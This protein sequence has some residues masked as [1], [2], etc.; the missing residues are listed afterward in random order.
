MGAIRKKDGAQGDYWT[1]GWASALR[2]ADR[3]TFSSGEQAR[4]AP[5]RAPIFATSETR[6]IRAKP[7]P[8]AHPQGLSLRG[9]RAPRRRREALSSIAKEAAHSTSVRLQH[10]PWPSALIGSY[11]LSIVKGVLMVW[12]ARLEP[13]S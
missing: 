7:R 2:R 11:F 1:G 10:A 13:V 5:T 4:R 6:D 8:S 3:R 9:P 12:R